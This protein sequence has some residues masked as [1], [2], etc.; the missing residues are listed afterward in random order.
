MRSLNEN[1]LAQLA[2]AAYFT[3]GASLSA[4]PAL[5]AAVRLSWRQ[6]LL[7]LLRAAASSAG[8]M[9]LLDGFVQSVQW[10]KGNRHSYDWQR[11]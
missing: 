10:L 8:F 7:R 6:I 4:V 1:E 3:F 5:V 11:P 9:F 2:Y